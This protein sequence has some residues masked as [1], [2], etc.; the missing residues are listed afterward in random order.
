MSLV[1]YSYNFSSY[2]ARK[3]QIHAQPGQL[4]EIASKL[5]IPLLL[6]IIIT[7]IT[8]ERL[9]MELKLKVLGS[10]LCSEKEKE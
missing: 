5:K 10:M 6:I 9:G 2:E 8:T 4:S 1:A 7:T 3:T